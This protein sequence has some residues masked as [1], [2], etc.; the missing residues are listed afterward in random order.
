MESL[1]FDRETTQERVDRIRLHYRSASTFPADEIWNRWLRG[2]GSR[3]KGVASPGEN[4]GICVWYDRSDRVGKYGTK[5]PILFKDAYT[6]R[7]YLVDN[8]PENV[9]IKSDHLVFDVDLND[10]STL[11]YCGCGKEKRSCAICWAIFAR[12]AMMIIAHFV[13]DILGYDDYQFVFSGRRGF[14]CW[15]LD[16]SSLSLPKATR[17]AITRG[18]FPSQGK[19]GNAWDPR[20]EFVRDMISRVGLPLYDVC[21]DDREFLCLIRRERTDEKEPPHVTLCRLVWP[22]LDADVTER[23]QH[24]VRC[25]YSLHIE[26]GCRARPL[27]SPEDNPHVD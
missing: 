24:G 12:G 13:S 2:Q 23:L 25:P 17:E 1:P 8:A 4:A 26:T 14:H 27:R 7:R 11:R 16:R 15:V 9:Q 10:Y 6:F 5:V 20:Q 19:V 21:R 3:R 18:W 22:R